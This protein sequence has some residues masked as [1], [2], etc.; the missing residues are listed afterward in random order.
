MCVE[1]EE[2]ETELGIENQRRIDIFIHINDDTCVI[3]ENKIDAGDQKNQLKDYAGS[4][5][6][7][8][9]TNK[10]IL[11]LTK[12]GKAPSEYSI[13][14]DELD[15]LN[16]CTVSY[17]DDI[18]GWLE[19][20]KT[21][22]TNDKDKILESALI[23]YID[24]LRGITN[25]RKGMKEMKLEITKE[26]LGQYKQDLTQLKILQDSVNHAV[27]IQKALKWIEEL[28]EK[29]T[30][31]SIYIGS[32]RHT[33]H[34]NYKENG[35]KFPQLQENIYNVEDDLKSLFFKVHTGNEIGNEKISVEFIHSKGIV[36]VGKL[37]VDVDGTVEYNNSIWVHDKNIK[38]PKNKDKFDEYNFDKN[39][40]EEIMKSIKK[41]SK[42]NNHE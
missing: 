10:Y 11:Y 22:I 15:K 29:Y 6:L 30:E 8:K 12:F 7:E 35:I 28:A 31:Y 41:Y 33:N 21:Q 34:T 24:T 40:V 38:K 13:S 1:R 36:Q 4:K 23:Q 17:R 25:T 20:C 37:W 42:P 32:P 27:M 14:K 16:F 9:Y 26:I 18:I 39:T 2:E 3:I 5:K 19:E